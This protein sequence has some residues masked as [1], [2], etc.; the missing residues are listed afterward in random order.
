MQPSPHTTAY[1]EKQRR[2]D[3]CAIRHSR[4]AGAQAAVLRGVAPCLDAVPAG[5]GGVH[6]LLFNTIDHSSLID[7]RTVTLTLECIVLLL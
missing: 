2:Q 7:V 3:R 5:R 4:Q 6:D 1:L